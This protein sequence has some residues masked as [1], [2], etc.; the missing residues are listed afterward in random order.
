MEGDDSDSSYSSRSDMAS[1]SGD[2]ISSSEFDPVLQSLR[3][4][5]LTSS[6]DLWNYFQL[7][8]YLRSHGMN[9]FG[10]LVENNRITGS[11]FVS[12]IDSP[13][14]I[15]TFYPEATPEE[16]DVLLVESRKLGLLVH[17]RR[18]GAVRSASLSRDEELSSEGI[19]TEVYET[20]TPVSRRRVK[21]MV[22]A[23][24]STPSPTKSFLGC[25]AN[26]NGAVQIRCNSPSLVD[27]SCGVAASTEIED[28]AKDWSLN[29]MS[30]IVPPSKRSQMFTSSSDHHVDEPSIHVLLETNDQ[31]NCDV[32]G[33][34]AWECNISTATARRISRVREDKEQSSGAD[35]HELSS[36][37]V[38]GTSSLTP[39]IVQEK[40]PSNNDG[41]E[42]AAAT[43]AISFYAQSPSSKEILCHTE[44]EVEMLKQ[45][46]VELE[47]KINQ[48][49]TQDPKSLRDD[50]ND[51]PQYLLLASVGV[52]AIVGQAILKK[53]I[54]SRF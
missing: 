15:E 26:S 20:S 52:C 13:A 47:E 3:N 41:A 14:S 2:S 8:N 44:S 45:R 11:Y 32:F 46:I 37:F 7:A 30:T 1:E 34:L 4:G 43:S 50:E 54:L 49:D 25:K 21:S 28:N 36:I 29:D 16:C 10:D 48:L 5:V 12:L 51:L 9:R 35:D 23:I 22:A 24:E 18:R 19:C 53:F 42:T 40:T 31:N 17:S 38:E 6:P 27:S 33:A 39:L